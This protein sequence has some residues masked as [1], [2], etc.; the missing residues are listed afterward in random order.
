[1]E[2]KTKHTPTPWKVMPYGDGGTYIIG[3]DYKPMGTAIARV[4][5]GNKKQ[6]ADAEF[7]V[8]CV[9]SHEALVEAVKNL[10]GIPHDFVGSFNEEDHSKDCRSCALQKALALAEGE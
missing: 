6:D 2:T 4:P 7:I 1:M 5:L 10:P 8:R 9:N 3:P